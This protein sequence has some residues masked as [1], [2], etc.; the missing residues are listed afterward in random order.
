MTDDLLSVLALLSGFSLNGRISPTRR[1]PDTEPNRD[2]LQAE[3]AAVD[4][5]KRAK[6]GT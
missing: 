3:I 1:E 6:K 2:K 5:K 4:A